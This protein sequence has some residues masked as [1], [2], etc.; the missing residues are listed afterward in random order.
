MPHMVD[1]TSPL[2]A[3]AFITRGA[4]FC[5]S[6]EEV[7]HGPTRPAANT[8]AANHFFIHMLLLFTPHGYSCIAQAGED[9]GVLFIL[10]IP[11][12]LDE[13][14]FCRAIAPAQL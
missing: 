5:A 7:A 9:D 8:D 4:L 6:T 12:F 1:C 13:K 2:G 14:L 10:P 11:S 3:L